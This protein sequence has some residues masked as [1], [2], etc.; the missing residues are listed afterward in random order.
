MSESI[1]ADLAALG[2]F[3][4]GDWYAVPPLG[5]IFDR[6]GNEVTGTVDD[7]YVRIKTS[8]RGREVSIMKHRAIWIAANKCVPDDPTLQIDHRDGDKQ[9]NRIANL[10]L[11]TPKENSNNPNAPNVRPGENH[12]Q[13]KITNAQAA[14]IRKRYAD[15]RGCPKGRGRLTTRQLASEYGLTHQ[16]ISRI[17][18]GKAYPEV[19]A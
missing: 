5:A 12:P 16:Q 17:I 1:N 19:A 6:F 18:R 14:E 13:A 10:V 15:T 7:G 2:K 11:V 8:F 9:N 3:V 4:N